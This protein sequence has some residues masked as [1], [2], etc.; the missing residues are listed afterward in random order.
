MSQL[1]SQSIT[2]DGHKFEVFKLAPLDAQDTLI[3]IVQALAPAAGQIANVAEAGGTSA[4]LD[5]DL[6]SVNAGQAIVKLSQGLTKVSMRALVKTMAEVTICDGKRLPD[7]MEIVFRGDL[8]LMYRWLWFALQVQFGNF[9]GP[10][11]DAI[12]SAT[13]AGEQRRQSQNTSGEN[14][15]SST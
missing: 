9:L 12:A 11:R 5:A 1:D 13:R 14:G 10:V 2:I 7:T 4:L 3:D 15:Q 8:P 6:G